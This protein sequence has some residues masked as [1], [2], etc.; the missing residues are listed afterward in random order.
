MSNNPERDGRKAARW[1]PGVGNPYWGETNRALWQKG[2]D[3]EFAVTLE[4]RE[5]V[6]KDTQCMALRI[7][8]ADCSD[9][10]KDIL[11]RI[12]EAS[13]IDLYEDAI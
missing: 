9:S 4:E 6:A 1:S 13:G 7:D 11:R 5:R 12:A 8:E 3:E 2:Y 10:V